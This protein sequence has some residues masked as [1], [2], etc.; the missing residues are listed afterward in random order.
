MTTDELAPSHLDALQAFFNGL[1]DGDLTFIKEDLDASMLRSWTRPE[2]DGRRW[3][4]VDDSGH[5][6]GFVALLP[7]RGWSRHVGELR[8]VVDPAARGQGVGRRL[9]QHALKASVEMDLTK[10]VVEVIA[11]QAGTIA[12][13][14]RLGFGAEA[15]LAD[16]IRDRHGELQDLVVLAHRLD[17][18]WSAMAATG[19]DDAVV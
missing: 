16:H 15:M 7:L 3:L 10:V 18:D 12:M 11:A 9:A 17:E 5:V 13:F 4:E 6:L 1:P 2:R 8:L 19:V 14:S